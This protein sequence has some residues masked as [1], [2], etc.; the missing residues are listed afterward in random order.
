MSHI[1]VESIE[2]TTELSPVWFDALI[3]LIMLYSFFKT[4]GSI[5][6]YCCTKTRTH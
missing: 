3:L 6:E 2:E 5:R 1:N 4:I